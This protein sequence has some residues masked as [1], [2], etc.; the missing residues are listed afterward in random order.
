[1]ANLGILA[2]FKPLDFREFSNPPS[3]EMVGEWIINSQKSNLSSKQAVNH[4]NLIPFQV[5]LTNQ[6][7]NILS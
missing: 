6:S 5:K 7:D 3:K 4:W 2:N 1:M